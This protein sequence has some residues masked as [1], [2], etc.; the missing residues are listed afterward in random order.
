MKNILDEAIEP[1][2][3]DGEINSEAS[4]NGD[5]ESI[6]STTDVLKSIN[7]SMEWIETQSELNI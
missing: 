5:E 1:E 3:E 6:P 2:G 7:T 4:V